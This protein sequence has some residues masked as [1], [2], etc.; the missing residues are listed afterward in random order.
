MVKREKQPI[1]RRIGLLGMSLALLA[2]PAAIT[3]SQQRIAMADPLFGIPYDP[4]EVR[5]EEAPA[6]IRRFCPYL[7]DQKLWTGKLWIYAHLKTEDAEYFVV[8]GY[9]T[10]YPDG[11]GPVSSEPGD[12]TAVALRGRKCTVDNS[13]YFLRG[14][15][16]AG[17]QRIIQVD[18]SVL[19][20]I[21][22]DALQRYANA[23]GGKNN[24]LKHVTEKDRKAVPPVLRKQLELFEKN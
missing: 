3:G 13:E 15:A 17:E 14:E 7:R 16:P 9:M 12:G 5:F 4:Q 11:P 1:I 20:R 8:S 19:N 21:A 23:F 6:K 24:F 18:G 10:I 22:A 2:S